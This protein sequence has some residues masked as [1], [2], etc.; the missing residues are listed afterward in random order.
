MY[1][2]QF[3]NRYVKPAGEYVQTT[4]IA[5][6][7]DMF[8]IDHTDNDTMYVVHPI[9]GYWIHEDKYVNYHYYYRDLDGIEY[10]PAEFA[11]LEKTYTEVKGGIY[12]DQCGCEYTKSG[13]VYTLITSYVYVDI[14]VKLEIAL[15][16]VIQ[17]IWD[18]NDV[19]QIF[20]W[21]QFDE[22]HNNG[23]PIVDYFFTDDIENKFTQEE[24]GSYRCYRLSQQ[25]CKLY[26]LID[27]PDN[28]RQVVITVIKET[29]RGTE[30]VSGPTEFTLKLDSGTT[31]INTYPLSNITGYTTGVTI[32]F[33]TGTYT[34][35]TLSGTPQITAG[36]LQGILI[37]VTSPSAWDSAVKPNLTITYSL[38]ESTPTWTVGSAEG[39]I[40]DD[41]VWKYED[42][43]FITKTELK[44]GD[45][46]VLPYM[47]SGYL[48]IIEWEASSGTVVKHEDEYKLVYVR[49]ATTIVPYFYPS[50]GDGGWMPTPFTDIGTYY[51]HEYDNSTGEYDMSTKYT[52]SGSSYKRVGE[53]GVPALVYHFIESTGPNSGKYVD[54]F[55][56]YWILTTAE[57]PGDHPD[58]DANGKDKYDNTYTK[59]LVEYHVFAYSE[60]E[61]RYV[62][63]ADTTGTVTLTPTFQE[64]TVDVTFTTNKDVYDA[65]GYQSITITIRKGETI[66]VG[67]VPALRDLAAY[68]AETGCTFERYEIGG[69]EF[70]P[71]VTV[72]NTDTAC[73]AVWSVTTLSFTF[74]TDDVNASISATRDSLSTLLTKGEPNTGLDYNTAITVSI[75]PAPGMAIDYEATI[76]ASTPG[77]GFGQPKKLAEDKGY[78]WSFPLTDNVTLNLRFKDV[79]TDLYFYVNGSVNTTIEV[80]YEGA[81]FDQFGNYYASD[82]VDSLTK[83]VVYVDHTQEVRYKI[84]HGV[85][86]TWMCWDGTAWVTVDSV[87]PYYYK[88][89][90]GNEYTKVDNNTYTKTS[91]SSTVTT[92]L[93]TS[94]QF[95]NIY[96]DHD[97]NTLV[98]SFVYKIDDGEKKYRITHGAPDTYEIWNG[99]S[100]ESVGSLPEGYYYKDGSGNEYT[101]VDNSTYTKRSNMSNVATVLTTSDQFGN[102]YSAHNTSSLTESLVYHLESETKYRITHG[103]PDTYEIWNG[104]GWES[105]GSLPEGYYYKDGSGNRYDKDGEEYVKRSDSS[106]VL[107][108]VT[109]TSNGRNIPLYTTVYF[110]NYNNG[111]VGWFT[112]PECDTDDALTPI[113]VSPDRY[114]VLMLSDLTLYTYDNYIVMLHDIDGTGERKFIITPD[115]G[116]VDIPAYSYDMINKH[117]DHLLVGWATK[118]SLSRAVYAYGPQDSIPV[119]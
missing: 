23:F 100:W 2:D 69:V 70:V 44:Y 11:V 37:S 5:F 78:R 31:F 99:A 4:K 50:D 45:T 49:E 52:L 82:L 71:G 36:V 25:Q 21:K 98:Y 75:K 33:G 40:Y 66:A 3:G 74:D 39:V 65:N 101:K 14:G 110:K 119:C 113:S 10:S 62:M 85:S 96:S 20:E 76:A 29:L 83:S 38:S 68:Q 112:N 41:S 118:E 80:Y 79:S 18:Y 95:G 89:S 34:G 26:A 64:D 107:P 61:F 103:A 108:T 60:N 46:I 51:Y 6:Q 1:L 27:S 8:K 77:Y 115:E 17:Y 12:I 88:D 59:T 24:D 55:G 67:D 54:T 106:H 81:A 73:V 53:G 72:F 97:V 104:A 22:D 42:G 93:T 94:D 13:L 109:T 19:K 15:G 86:D 87:A 32:E 116:T 63:D 57:M 84:V 47:N 90:E 7:E 56:G 111:D 43:K 58:V 16:G 105:V 48:P 30:T 91:D 114:S 35:W 92:V 102:V 28:Q 117:A 9:H